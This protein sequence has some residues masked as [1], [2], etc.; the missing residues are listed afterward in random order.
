MKNMSCLIP[1]VFLFSCERKTE[2]INP[3][4]E[5]ITESV[6]ASGQLKSR[7]QYEAFSPVNGIIDSIHIEEGELVKKGSLILTI[8]NV[9]AI[10]RDNAELTAR[11]SSYKSN[12]GKIEEA[13]L[14]LD[15]A[16]AKLENDSLSFFRRER[17]WKQ[18]IGS[19]IEY[20]QNALVFQSSKAAYFS[21]RVKYSDLKKQLTLSDAQSK[22]NLLISSRL[23]DDYSLKSKINGRLYRLHKKKGEVVAPQMPLAIIGD[24]SNFVLE[25]QV[26]EYDIF[27]VRTGMPVL[28][29]LD[30]YKNNIFHATVEKIDP[31]MDEQRR[32]FLVEA[33]F[34][35]PPPRLFPNI[36]FEANIIVGAKNSA[37]LVPRNYVVGDS[38][39]YKRNGKKSVVKTGLKDY[40]K[41]EIL[42]GIGIDDELILPP[43]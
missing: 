41:I 16:R 5:S 18:Q 10:S 12:E 24:A 23:T 38:L 35:A 25:M 17:L 8:E 30:S 40:R 32:T 27:K 14:A 37:M 6:Y 7:F 21:A 36:S 39:V 34:T 43:P 33:K 26:D 20:E 42:S 28:I 31:I 4:V 3:M 22:A 1:L 15:L 11:L 2:P 13:K 9:Q 29:T 19:K